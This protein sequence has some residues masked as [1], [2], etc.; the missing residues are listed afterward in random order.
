M[1]AEDDVFLPLI[2]PEGAPTAGSSAPSTPSEEPGVAS[3][4]LPAGDV[5]TRGVKGS[6]LCQCRSSSYIRV[7]GLRLKSTAKLFCR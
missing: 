6:E 3:A 7:S 1:D 4:V 2:L 5:L